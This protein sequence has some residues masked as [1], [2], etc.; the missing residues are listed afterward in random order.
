MAS[1]VSACVAKSLKALKSRKIHFNISTQSPGGLG[2][3]KCWEVVVIIFM[4]KPAG[5]A[6][7]FELLLVSGWD[8]ACH[9]SP[10]KKRSRSGVHLMFRNVQSYFCQM[11]LYSGSREGIPAIGLPQ[12]FAVWPV[13]LT[14]F[15]LSTAPCPHDS[16]RSSRN[17][18]GGW[19][20]GM[21]T[22]LGSTPSTVTKIE[23]VNV[24]GLHPPSPCCPSP[25]FYLEWFLAILSLWAF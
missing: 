6:H 20:P 7:P 24:A 21:H 22:A 2:R 11:S 19:V 25:L 1:H 10:K 17:V 23:S 15:P 18:H 14:G 3:V 13:S 8:N 16:W 5:S 12:C 4:L 9:G